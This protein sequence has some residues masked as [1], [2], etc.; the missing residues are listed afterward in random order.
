MATY[1]VQNIFVEDTLRFKPAGVTAGY[2]LSINASGD[3]QWIVAPSG[4]SYS[5]TANFVTYFD[6]T[7]HIAT[8]SIKISSNNIDTYAMNVTTATISGSYT[9][10]LDKQQYVYNLS[11][12]TEFGY[13]SPNVSTYNFLVNAGT[14]SFTLT[15]G[16]F[17][18]VGA[19]AL[20][21]TASFV[22]SG[23]Y[24]GTRMWVSTVQNYT[25]L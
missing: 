22:M 19:T 3:S 2:I 17:K 16:Q 12:N 9:Q 10:A 4:L 5:S 25:N 1:S 23:V 14:Y 20:S 18:T 13:S 21:Y 15:T 6:T 24:D 11:G 7:S 8:A